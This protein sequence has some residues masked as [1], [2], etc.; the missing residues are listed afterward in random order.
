M[1]LLRLITTTNSLGHRYCHL[2][3]PVP[4]PVPQTHTCCVAIT[5]CVRRPSVRPSVRLVV[6]GFVRPGLRGLASDK[7]F[8]VTE[9]LCHGNKKWKWEKNVRTGKQIKQNKPVEIQVPA[10]L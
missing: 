5:L 2:H 7:H 9:R 4:V 8:E 1:L 10:S 3:G 6:S